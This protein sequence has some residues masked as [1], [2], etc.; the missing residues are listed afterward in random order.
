MF[1]T[2]NS[3]TVLTHLLVLHHV[4]SCK[5]LVTWVTGI[6]DAH[7]CFGSR[8]YARGRT[9]SGRNSAC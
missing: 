3:M 2:V 1:S 9:T 8:F 5:S 7:V 6:G 4:L